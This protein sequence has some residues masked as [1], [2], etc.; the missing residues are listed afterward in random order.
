MYYAAIEKY[1]HNV[2]RT[3]VIGESPYY[4]D[5]FVSYADGDRHFVI[6]LVK[7]LEEE[8]NL[9]LCIHHRDFIPGTAI[10]DNITNAIHYSRRTVCFITSHFIKS[11]WCMFELNMAR[12]EAIYSRNG[13]NVLFL[14]ILE[15]G[16]VKKLPRSFMD[17]IELKSYLDFP[18]SGSPDEVTAFRSTLGNTLSSSESDIRGVHKNV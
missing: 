16:A 2:K 12:M 17:L 1:R 3:D 14:V 7:R 9:K 15:T 5:A 8:Y 18:G 13:E 6:D 10:D 11:S 4:F